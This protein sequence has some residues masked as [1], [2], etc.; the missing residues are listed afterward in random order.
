MIL[1]LVVFLLLFIVGMF[2][3][4]DIVGPIMGL[5][6]LFAILGFPMFVAIATGNPLWLFLYLLYII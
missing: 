6:V 1:V 3:D 5:L 2:T 4:E